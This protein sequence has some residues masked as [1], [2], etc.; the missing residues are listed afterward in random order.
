MSIVK[1]TFN[2]KEDISEFLT[3]TAEEKGVTVTELLGRIISNGI[4][5]DQVDKKGQMIFTGSD[6]NNLRR[7]IFK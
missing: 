2:V 3:R 1:V 4:F 7:V 5:L 6:I